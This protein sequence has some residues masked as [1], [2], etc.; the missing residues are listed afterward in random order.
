MWVWPAHS[1]DLMIQLFIENAW[2]RLNSCFWK[3]PAWMQRAIVWYALIDVA[4]DSAWTELRFHRK[5]MSSGESHTRFS[6]NMCL[7]ALLELTWKTLCYASSCPKEHLLA[8]LH[9]ACVCARMCVCV[10]VCAHVCV[11]NMCMHSMHM[12]LFVS[13]STM[14]LGWDSQINESLNDYPENPT[15]TKSKI[16]RRLNQRLPRKSYED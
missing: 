11:C 8:I 2:V 9:A 13:L 3:I 12:Y 15:K 14:L 10:C 5:T 1:S 7:N 16:L 6:T 4:N